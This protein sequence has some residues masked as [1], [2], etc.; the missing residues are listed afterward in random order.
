MDQDGMRE[1]AGTAPVNT[2]DR[3]CIV[4][5]KFKLHDNPYMG[6]SSL[7]RYRKSIS[8]QLCGMDNDTTAQI[9]RTVDKNFDAMS[10]SIEGQILEFEEYTLRM[11][12]DFDQ[13]NEAIV[14]NLNAS[15]ALFEQAIARYKK[16]MGLNPDDFHTGYLLNRASDEYAYLMSFLG[17][18]NPP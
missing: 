7:I 12:Q 17:K 4:F 6:I 2:D 16:A 1:Y 18:M 13:P 11:K 3:P 5:S 10:N 8:A 14:K 9:K 15:K